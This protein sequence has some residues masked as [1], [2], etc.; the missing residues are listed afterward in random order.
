MC[1]LSPKA[2]DAHT[3]LCEAGLD[4]DLAFE[5]LD[6]LLSERETFELEEPED[7]RLT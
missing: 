3:K 1:Y 7:E 5:I 2:L 4:S 6:K